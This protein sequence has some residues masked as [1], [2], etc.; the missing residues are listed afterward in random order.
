MYNT[1]PDNS[2]PQGT[3]KYTCRPQRVQRDACTV[4]RYSNAQLSTTQLFKTLTPQQPLGWTACL[5]YF[6]WFASLYSKYKQMPAAARTA[7]SFFS[8]SA[9]RHS[10]QFL[11]P[12]KYNARKCGRIPYTSPL[13]QENS[14][15]VQCVL[16]PHTGHGSRLLSQTGHHA[17]MRSL[18]R[19][20][21]ASRATQIGYTSTLLK[22]KKKRL[23]PLPHMNTLPH[24]RVT[25]AP[26][27]YW[28]HQ[29]PCLV[30]HV[31]RRKL[32]AAPPPSV[33]DS[34]CC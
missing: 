3:V 34:F 27:C 32:L 10:R 14:G 5:P 12:A 11:R 7:T 28:A 6:L 26:S 20:S 24:T 30:T 8:T 15:N 18:T 1:H 4:R 16:P 13:A 31:L 17:G 2:C 33:A 29:Q 9:I 19:Q 25:P 23:V 21:G 22:K